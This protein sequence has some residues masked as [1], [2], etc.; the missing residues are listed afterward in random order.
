M[1]YVTDESGFIRLITSGQ[2]GT[3]GGGGGVGASTVAGSTI[4]NSLNLFGGSG[5]DG[6]TGVVG[7][8]VQGVS[9][10][11]YAVGCNGGDGGKGGSGLTMAGGVATNTW[12]VGGGVPGKGADAFEAV[13]SGNLG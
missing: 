9:V 5:G 11:V 13:A 4:D 3:S 1:R 12:F 6:G 8:C 10:C 2:S 7:P